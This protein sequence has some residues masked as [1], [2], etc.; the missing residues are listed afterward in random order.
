MQTIHY[1]LIIAGVS[2]LFARGHLR[3]SIFQFLFSHLDLKVLGSA[4]LRIGGTPLRRGPAL[5]D[6]MPA[7]SLRLDLLT[8][9]QAPQPAFG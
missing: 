9:P 3:F 2:R 7:Q 5:L 4:N 6:P 1:A 8:F